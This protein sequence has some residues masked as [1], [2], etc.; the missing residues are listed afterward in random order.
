MSGVILAL[1]NLILLA[2]WA[3]VKYY[4][5]TR[6]CTPKPMTPA[7][8]TALSHLVQI[9]QERRTL[10]LDL[11]TEMVLIFDVIFSRGKGPEH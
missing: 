5:H 2:S 4:L 7:I 8:N 10:L 9:Y 6:K 11:A 3:S 1:F